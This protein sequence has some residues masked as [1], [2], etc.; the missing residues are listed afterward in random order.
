MKIF[1][2]LTKVDEA[3]R[4]VYGRAVQET[5][6]RVNEVFDYEKSKPN[7]VEWSEGIAKATD[8]KSLGNVRAMHGKVAAGKL[9]QI[10]F[11]DAEKAIDVVAEIVDENEWNKVVK[12]VYTGFSIGGKYGDRWT[13]TENKELTRYVAIPSEVSL[14]DLPCIPTANFT[15]VKADGSTAEVALV[16]D[17]EATASDEI[18]KLI[19]GGTIKA[20]DLRK[21]IDAEMTKS[22]A[23]KIAADEQARADALVAILNNDAITNGEVES[24]AAKYLTA[25]EIAAIAG[26]GVAKV[27]GMLV[28]L[29]AKGEEIVK[30]EFSQKQRDNAADKGQAMPD[31]SFPIKN[32]ED[33]KNAVQAY[34]R[35][36][37]KA[38]AK[39]H[40]IRRAKA[41]GAT[42]E[43]PENWKY[44]GDGD[45]G[46]LAAFAL[47]KGLGTVCELA[48]LIQSLWWLQRGCEYEQEMEG[49]AGSVLPARLEAVCVELGEILCEMAEEETQEE[50]GKTIIADLR[51]VGARNSKADQDKIQAVHDHS[52]SL[53]AKCADDSDKAAL[54]TLVK[55]LGFEGADAEKSAAAILKKARA[56]DNLPAAPRGMAQVVTKAQETSPAGD[57]ADAQDAE[58]RKAVESGD[59]KELLKLT[60]RYGG[61]Q[62]AR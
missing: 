1:A 32:K 10:D 3:Q 36:K 57:E 7:F 19:E 48:N 8:G 58:I 55:A 6:D 20:T 11:V 24:A 23:E 38:A 62:G 12:G 33:L 43:L 18:A 53:G 56:W 13:D 21:L 40:I 14:V 28:A 47:E 60:Y 16:G 59:P 25:E 35:A 49:D 30:R 17:P 46:K 31:G 41:L 29:R 50:A 2:R 37:N 45:L 42:D 51:K 9:A 34:G 27:A 5:P 4:R 44:S 54:A 52:V 26:E 22:A 61:R 15:M 39:K